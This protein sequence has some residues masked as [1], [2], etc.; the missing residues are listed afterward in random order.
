VLQP[1]TTCASCYC[2]SAYLDIGDHQKSLHHFKKSLENDPD[3]SD[4]YLNIANLYEL[5]EEHDQAI[6]TYKTA[7]DKNPDNHKAQDALNRLENFY[8][9]ESEEEESKERY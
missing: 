7:L 8:E 2:T 9:S 1:N 3:N 5:L 6:E 4:I